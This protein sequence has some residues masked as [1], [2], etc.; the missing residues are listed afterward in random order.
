MKQFITVLVVFSVL[1][2]SCSLDESG[3]ASPEDGTLQLSE[4]V[5]GSRVVIGPDL[6]SPYFR[7]PS[8][9]YPGQAIGAGMSMRV[10]NTGTAVAI[11]GTGYVFIGFYLSTDTQKD[12]TD[13]L[14]VGGRE[15]VSTPIAVNQVK[16]VSIYSGMSIPAGTA[17]GAYYLLG[18]VDEFNHVAE[19]NESNNVIYRRIYIYPQLADLEGEDFEAPSSASPGEQ[20]G[21]DMALM[22]KNTGF[23]AATS[24]R[25][26]F[27][28][29]FYLSADS[30]FDAS[31]VLLLGGRESVNTPIAVDDSVAVSIYDGMSIPA[32][33]ATGSYYLFAVIDEF[34]D[35]N[36]INEINHMRRP[37]T[38]N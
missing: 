18:V 19:I 10:A 12:G 9:A 2:A 17:Y 30:T 32:G 4:A 16:N 37:I 23:I 31:D 8:K 20:I 24:A 3:P 6:R 35:V 25:S 27:F 34:D 28:V 14:L 5:S 29:G 33:T 15:T 1:L 22:V 38:I 11:S 26:Y 13:T 7:A 21:A 36:E